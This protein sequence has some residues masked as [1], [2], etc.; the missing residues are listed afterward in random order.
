M[1]QSAQDQCTSK[2]DIIDSKASMSIPLTTW[3]RQWNILSFPWAKTKRNKRQKKYVSLVFQ[4]L[5]SLKNYSSGF[6][7]MTKCNF[8]AQSG[9]FPQ[10]RKFFK[11]PVNEPCFF[12]SC[13][14]TW[15]K[16]KS[17]I[18]LLVKYRRLKN[19]EI[20]LAENN[21]WL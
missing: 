19:T 2:W 9:P 16:S 18:Y 20:S 5:P 13:L 21:F 6:R 17:D 3:E 10:M 4:Q 11:K 8:W 12:Q 14:F 1:K 15:Q 7:V